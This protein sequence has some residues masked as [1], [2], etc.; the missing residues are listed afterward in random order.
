MNLNK[1]TK[2]ELISKFKK[3]DNKN[4]NNQQTF[5]QSI[6]NSLTL[7]KNILYKFTILTL[8]IKTF[9]KYSI[10]RRIWLILNTIVMSIFGISILNFYGLSFIA[11]FYSEFTSLVG[12]LVNYL[13]NTHFYS[14][15]SGLFGQKVDVKPATNILGMGTNNNSSTGSETS[16]ENNSKINEWLN[17]KEIIQEPESDNRKYYIMAALF[18]LSCLA[19]YYYGDEIKT[20]PAN[21]LE[22]VRNFR[23]RPDD[24]PDNN[25]PILNNVPDINQ[26]ITNNR[27]NLKDRFKN[28]F[29]KDENKSNADIELVDNT[30]ATEY[31]TYF[32]TP[33][34]TT[35]SEISTNKLIVKGKE[36][37]TSN[38]SESEVNRRILQ[39]VT[40]DEFN[41]FNGEAGVLLN[42][43][44]LF[45]EKHNNNSI[46]VSIEEPMY[47][48]LKTKLVALSMLSSK[49]YSD[50]LKDSNVSNSV[51]NFFEL[52]KSLI[53]SD[54]I[55]EKAEDTQS[56]TY[57]EIA[58]ATTEEQKAWSQ[59]SNTSINSPYQQSIQQEV[60]SNNESS[61]HSPIIEDQ[62]Q[63][64]LAEFLQR[65]DEF[66][67]P[68]DI[69]QQIEDEINKG[70]PS[71]DA[72][73]SL[74]DAIK[75][76]RND[77]YVIDDH[78]KEL[79]EIDINSASNSSID[80]ILPEQVS[81]TGF[82]ALF[83]AI[84]SKRDD[85]N[86]VSS[87]NISNIGL[88]PI[89]E[90]VKGL[91]TPKTDTLNIPDNTLQ[92]KP[93]FSN[94]LEDTNALF[95]DDLDINIPTDSTNIIDNTNINYIWD[96]WDTKNITVLDNKSIN[97]NLNDVWQ[98][99]KA[100]HITTH[101]N[102]HVI[103]NYSEL[104]HDNLNKNIFKIDLI[105]QIPKILEHFPT[106]KIKEVLI[107]DLN[108]KFNSIYKI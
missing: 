20:I 66:F 85:S 51:L 99:T 16:I 68:K 30:Q 57:N 32:E 74:L 100:I 67:N 95:D 14:V 102:H 19:W 22:K 56:D 92:N 23:R 83:D 104:I 77:S 21:V 45:M 5:F 101:E 34:S 58:L 79:P 103:I 10:F 98:F 72:R 105:D 87:P 75:S 8:L 73:S 78:N 11:S 82:N 86:V 53:N 97:I 61:V 96:K 60:L 38:L 31:N 89:L 54:K 6:L 39:Q 27:L 84:K 24:N 63:S 9:K 93:S 49:L 4:S 36:I 26:P 44:N 71:I 106:V 7:F 3:L 90:K 50:W 28:L 41:K 18:L 69:N 48:A 47:K 80:D 2:A 52:E 29:Y 43:M 33:S 46:P 35:S 107:E 64:M 15:L 17:R 70:K 108:N 76:R 55:S 94:L 42:R 25:Q 88:T 91:F 12:N 13:T 59:D 37:D 62:N 65:G 81:K 40:G 1:F